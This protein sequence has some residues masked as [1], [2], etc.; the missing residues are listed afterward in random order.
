M[1][2]FCTLIRGDLPPVGHSIVF[3]ADAEALPLPEFDGYCS[4]WV[5]SGTSALALALC[6]AKALRK[7]IAAPEVIVPGYCCPDLVAAANYAG[8]TV[9]V[10]DIGSDDPS[11][12]ETALL[13]AITVNTIAV[14]AVNFMGVKEDGNKFER[15]KNNYPNLLII[16]DNAQWF[17]ESDD[18]KNFSGDFVIFS[19]GRGKPVSLLGGGLMLARVAHWNADLV[20]E[21]T[22][23]SGI[24]SRVKRSMQQLKYIAYNSLLAPNIYQLLNRTPFITLGGTEYHALSEIVEMDSYRQ[25]L[26]N[27][28]IAQY[29]QRVRDNEVLMDDALQSIG[30]QNAFGAVMSSRRQRLLRYPVLFNNVQQ[31]EVAFARLTRLGLGATEMYKNHLPLVAGV[32]GN[33]VVSGALDNA[34]A[35]AARFISLPLHAGVKPPHIE[36]I[37]NILLN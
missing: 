30:F 5:N 29:R 1:E 26:V 12:D 18:S 20:D 17:P 14:I 2:A 35:F 16:E 13:Q 19:F 8:V 10:V 6:C 11:Y 24:Q 34:A 7:E 22:S 37:K 23:S 33:V 9:V 4:A 31:K 27:K 25:S 21:L 28:N 32:E 36:L 3:T 15:L